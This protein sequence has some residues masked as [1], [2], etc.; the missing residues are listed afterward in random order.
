MVQQYRPILD[1]PRTDP[2][3]GLTD[4][5]GRGARGPRNVQ[6]EQAVVGRVLRPLD[7]QVVVVLASG[8]SEVAAV[9]HV[10]DFVG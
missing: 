5:H 9:L 3:R 8:R 1:D 10:L 6:P 7:V 4:R 2:V